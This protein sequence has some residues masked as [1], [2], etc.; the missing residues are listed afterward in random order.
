MGGQRYILPHLKS[1][2]ERSVV[3]RSSLDQYNLPHLKSRLERSVVASSSL[4]AKIWPGILAGVASFW[5]KWGV[6]DN[7]APLKIKN[8]AIM[9]FDYV[10]CLLYV[11]GACFGDRVFLA[12]VTRL[13]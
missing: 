7:F 8:R 12:H 11:A 6:K 10:C 9:R 13:C 5:L 3:A 4:D 1:R 2:L